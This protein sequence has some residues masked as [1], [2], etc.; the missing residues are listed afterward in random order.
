MS[1]E[2][3]N[4]Q[5]TINMSETVLTFNKITQKYSVD[6]TVLF[7]GNGNKDFN[8][9]VANYFNGCLS[10]TVPERFSDGEIKI[11]PIEENCRQKH[12]VIIQCCNYH[13]EY[14]INDLLME[15]FV[16][17][18]TVKRSNA[19]SITVV[20][21]I[22]PYQRQDRKSYSRSPI[23]ASMVAGMLEGL[24]I[25]RVICF[26]LHAGQIQGFFHK[27][28]V[29]NLTIDKYFVDCVVSL[30]DNLNMKPNEFVIV[31]PDEGG[32]K[33]ASKL[34]KLLGCPMALLHK[35]R[36]KPNEVG[37]MVLMGDVRGRCCIIVDDMIDTAG[38][39]M[40]ACK[41]LRENGADNISVMVCHGIL[42]GPAFDRIEACDEC[43]YVFVSN[44][45]DVL[46]RLIIKDEESG[47]IEKRRTDKIKI[48][49]I[50]ELCAAAI[51]KGL[52]GESVSELI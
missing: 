24:D 30:A 25:D 8:L 1:I 9:K 4:N 15:V 35:E 39:A 11:P 32:V 41:V 13:P 10:K 40:K 12:C 19:K 6:D 43:D 5:K 27:V 22:F 34:A 52:K 51:Y 21:P 42:S 16:L 48:I 47:I 50:S 18:D 46:S 31:S 20:L 44:T 38:T 7:V 49:D 26:E 14:S 2:T 37:K 45:V 17:I 36:S 28:P 3:N 29:D 23:T 33:R